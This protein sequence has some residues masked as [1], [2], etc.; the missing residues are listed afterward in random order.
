MPRLFCPLPLASGV[1][2]DLPASAARHV[3]VL[4]MQPG[5]SVTLFNGKGGEY[6]AVID[7]M[8][9]SIVLPGCEAM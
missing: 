2:L 1:T 6:A 7:R 3:Q 4:R 9:D 5:E 8:G